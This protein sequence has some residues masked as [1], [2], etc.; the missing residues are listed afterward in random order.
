MALLHALI[1]TVQKLL[2]KTPPLHSR[3]LTQSAA[4]LACNPWKTESLDWS[5]VWDVM[6]IGS[7]C[8]PGD[9]CI[10]GT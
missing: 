7:I 8:V 3:T 4:L 2:K 10:V 9:G 1:I 6:L 5:L